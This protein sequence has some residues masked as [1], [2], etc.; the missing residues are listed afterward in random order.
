MKKWHGKKLLPDPTPGKG[1]Q[2][3]TKMHAI[4]SH[5]YGPNDESNILL[6]S[7]SAND[8]HSDEV[9]EPIKNYLKKKNRAVHYSVAVTY[10][11]PGFVNS[12]AHAALTSTEQTE[13]ANWKNHAIAHTINCQAIYYQKS[14]AGWEASA[15]ETHAIDALTTD[16]KKI[17]GYRAAKKQ[18][19]EKYEKKRT[20]RK[21]KNTALYQGIVEALIGLGGGT[22]QTVKKYIDANHLGS[23]TPLGIRN[24][25]VEMKGKALLLHSGGKYQ[26]NKRT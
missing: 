5:L 26:I 24:M 7:A 10:G 16:H 21:M 4:N 17:G 23:W 2:A 1:S 20:K 12:P 3:L 6:G 8:K 15:P 18:K 19:V 13:F 22:P 14:S 9:E 25:M 11:H